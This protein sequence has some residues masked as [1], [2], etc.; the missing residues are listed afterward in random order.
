[1]DNEEKAITP[2]PTTSSSKAEDA[3]QSIT[4]DE[5]ATQP[6]TSVQIATDDE[7]LDDS[8]QV[9]T[10][11][12]SPEEASEEDYPSIPSIIT[13][14]ALAAIDSSPK[15]FLMEPFLPV[16]GTALIAGKPDTGKSQFARQLAITVSQGAESFIGFNLDLKHQRAVY[17]AT[18][19]DAINCNFLQ[20]R[21]HTGLGYEPNDNLCFVFADNMSQSV[22]ISNLETILTSKP[23][24]LVIVDSFSDVFQGSDLNNN[25]QMRETARTFDNLA[26][27]Y[28][29]LVLFVHHINKGAYDK[30]PTQQS[31]QGGSGLAQKVRLAWQMSS[32]G[33]NIKSLAVTKG[34]YTPR[35]YKEKPIVL[36]FDE[37]TFTFTRASDDVIVKSHSTSD[38][39]EDKYEKKVRKYLPDI[40]EVLLQDQGMKYKTFLD[41]LQNKKGIPEATAKRMIKWLKENKFVELDEDQKLY[42]WCEKTPEEVNDSEDY[43]EEEEDTDEEE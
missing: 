4:S 8:D 27:K 12:T 25:F 39:Q 29:C 10:E 20:E 43:I 31:I 23:A 24:D 30:A 34:N 19:D 16:T 3:A 38:K 5:Q 2:K 35:E 41:F 33:G 36:N 22:L 42:M 11:F 18:E 17:V 21:Q 37:I 40:E 32:E 26:K 1:M 28:K 7:G 13:A 6:D 14:K 15:R 9:E